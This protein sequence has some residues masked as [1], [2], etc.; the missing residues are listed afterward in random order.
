MGGDAKAVSTLLSEISRAS[1]EQAKGIEQNN[2]AIQGMNLAA[3]PTTRTAIAGPS[4]E[5]VS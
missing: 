3:T 5:F 4:D 1:E 2:R